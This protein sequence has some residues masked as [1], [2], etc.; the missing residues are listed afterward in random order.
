MLLPFAMSTRVDMLLRTL[1]RGNLQRSMSDETHDIS[2]ADDLTL[3]LSEAWVAR[4]YELVRTARE[5][6]KERGAEIPEKL[7]HLF[8]Q[9]ELV[10]MPID[11]GEINKAIHHKGEPI[12]LTLGDGSDP[13]E[14]KKGT[15]VLQRGMCGQTGA[16]MWWPIDLKTQQTVEVCRRDLSDW[17]LGLFD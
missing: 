12:V 14:Y 7:A 5:S 15:F 11:K 4:C 16:T 13:K 17:L 3:S 8:Y 6:I 9:L 10:R 2:F 1:E